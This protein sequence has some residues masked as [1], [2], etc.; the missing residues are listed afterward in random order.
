MAG[1]GVQ[2]RHADGNGRKE[3]ARTMKNEN[4]AGGPRGMRPVQP[5]KNPFPK[6]GNGFSLKRNQN[7]SRRPRLPSRQAP[8]GRNAPKQEMAACRAFGLPCCSSA[9]LEPWEQPFTARKEKRASNRAV[10]YAKGLPQKENLRQARLKPG[11][12]A[13]A[14]GAGV[15]PPVPSSKRERESK[16]RCVLPKRRFAA[17]T[18]LAAPP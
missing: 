13:G 4:C 9:A 15:G 14:K 12:T 11:T 18:A 7:Q 10:L 3:A 8:A 17:S 5:T 2:E 6:L 16:P 1:S